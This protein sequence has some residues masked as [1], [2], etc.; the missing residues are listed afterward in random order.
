MATKPQ[1]L[2]DLASPDELAW[3]AALCEANHYLAPTPMGDGKWAA[4]SPFIFTNGIITGTMFDDWGY[5]DRWCYEHRGL[6]MAALVEWQ[7]RGF[8]GEPVGWHRH[9]D[10]GR[11]RPD[12]DASK[13]YIN[14]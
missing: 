1:P 3:L 11:R 14:K 13:E 5:Q 6:A 2:P 8:E 10:S 9:P 7:L 4:I 12:G